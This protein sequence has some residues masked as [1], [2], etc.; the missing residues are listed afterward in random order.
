MPTTSVQQSVRDNLALQRTQLANE[1]TLLAYGRTA[2]MLVGSGAT[3]LK[4][5]G[6]LRW[7]FALGWML[8]VAGIGAGL[9][10]A[11]RYRRFDAEM[12]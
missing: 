9:L 6:D 1:R 12:R 3:V 10:G 11:Y 5:Y 2:L 8:I 7:E 4:L